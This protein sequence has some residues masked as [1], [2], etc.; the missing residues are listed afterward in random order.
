MIATVLA[1]TKLPNLTPRRSSAGAFS[2]LHDIM[3]SRA[4]HHHFTHF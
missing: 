3:R 2:A 4:R 1:E